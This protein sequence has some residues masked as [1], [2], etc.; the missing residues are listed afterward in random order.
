MDLRRDLVRL[1]R[2]WQPQRVVC[3]D[4][5]FRYAPDGYINHPD[6]LRCIELFG[7]EVLP[8]LRLEEPT[9]EGHVS[10]GVNQDD[11]AVRVGHT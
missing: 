4:P 6:T 10:V 7:N 3:M 8:A 2:K 1:I 5:S 9:A 11:V